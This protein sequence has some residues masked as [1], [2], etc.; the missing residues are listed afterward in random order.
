[1]TTK[2]CSRLLWRCRRGARELDSLLLAYGHARIDEL[3]TTELDNLDMLLEQQNPDI[4][5]WFLGLSEPDEPK[6]AAAIQ[7]VLEFK[8][9]R[10]IG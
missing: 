4:L 10:E 8:E 5:N 9:R 1:M 6:I 7:D 3:N 2:E